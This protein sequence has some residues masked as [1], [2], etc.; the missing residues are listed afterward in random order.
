MRSAPPR[1]NLPGLLM[2]DFPHDTSIHERLVIHRLSMEQ[3]LEY[4]PDINIR[5]YRIHDEVLAKQI[6][7]DAWIWL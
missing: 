6:E 2:Q 4:E 5:T 7:E 1:L 3:V